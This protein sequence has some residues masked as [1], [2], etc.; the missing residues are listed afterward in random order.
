[1][2]AVKDLDY[3]ESTLIKNIRKLVFSSFDIN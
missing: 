3:E 1:M 2:Y